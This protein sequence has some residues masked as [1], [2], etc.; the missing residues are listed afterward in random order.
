MILR[1]WE[2]S[3]VEQI[4]NDFQLAIDKVINTP[5][6]HYTHPYTAMLLLEE[7]EREKNDK[8]LREYV[9]KID[10]IT[11]GINITIRP[12][13]NLIKLIINKQSSRQKHDK[14]K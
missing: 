4:I 8:M 1:K 5:F 10:N 14:K 9:S 7:L 12:C 3:T 2:N 13:I 6:Y 11:K